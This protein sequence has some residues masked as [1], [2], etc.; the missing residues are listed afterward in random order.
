M[1]D[2]TPPSKKQELDSMIR[3]FGVKLSDEKRAELRRELESQK[4][5]FVAVERVHGKGVD[6]DVSR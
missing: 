3:D 4:E 6:R 1:Q 5:K 2:Q